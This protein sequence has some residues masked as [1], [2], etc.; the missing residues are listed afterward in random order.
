MNNHAQAGKQAR[1]DLWRLGI[2]VKLDEA[3]FRASGPGLAEHVPIMKEHRGAMIVGAICDEF[4]LDYD[5]MMEFWQDD[6]EIFAREG[7]AFA[8]ACAGEYAKHREQY[9][10]DC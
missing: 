3:E 9:L 1:N 6:L 8:R 4:G 10:G 2:R 5:E 7:V